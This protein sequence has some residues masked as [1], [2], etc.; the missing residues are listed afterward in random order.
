[1]ALGVLASVPWLISYFFVGV[2]GHDDSH[3]TFYVAREL[4][5]AGDYVNYNRESVEQSSSM[6]FVLILAAL[7]L[8]T[9]LSLPLL[10]W[11][12]SMLG[13]S[14]AVVLTY[15][16]GRHLIEGPEEHKARGALVAAATC[17]TTWCFLYWSTSAMEASV[18]AAVAPWLVI[19]MARYEQQP[20][21]L[22]R[23][24][25]FA[26]AL[27][28]F[29]TL[30]PENVVIALCVAIALAAL[31]L[32]EPQ[33]KWYRSMGWLIAGP[34]ALTAVRLFFFGSALPHPVAA[35]SGGFHWRAGLEY[36]VD[37]MV[38]S[39]AALFIGT[40]LA[41]ASTLVLFARGRLRPALGV[42]SAML[43][44]QLAFVVGSGGDW[45][46]HGRF[47]VPAIPL[48]CVLV[49]RLLTTVPGRSFSWAM[50]IVLLV[51]ML[52]VYRNIDRTHGEMISFRDG[53]RIATHY[54]IL[55]SRFTR[56]ELAC[57]PHLRD[58]PMVVV[59]DQW[60]SKLE[61]RI[62]GPPV[63]S[64]G[65]AGMIPYYASKGRRIRFVDL[66]DVTSGD[67]EKCA[68]GAV[69]RRSK[70]GTQLHLDWVLDGR[71]ETPCGLPRPHVAFGDRLSS[72]TQQ[73]LNRNGYEVVYLQ[74]G[75]PKGK[76]FPRGYQL[77]GYIAVRKDLLT[78]EERQ[79]G[80]VRYTWQESHAR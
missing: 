80:T 46:V 18:A 23:V 53:A 37:S 40:L 26:L 65:Q 57:P 79:A 47:L 22:S 32:R 76:D 25:G 42:A 4:L 71:L 31:S 35:K 16:L 34:A 60:L 36:A 20:R 44:S 10:G 43:F 30:R 67:V 62:E 50:L 68:P 58:A 8:V 77:G 55:D 17:A 12:V 38:A 14:A 64:S 9:G 21:R 63:L 59:L 6:G 29:I 33:E 13:G 69:A 73:T 75:Q 24:A 27:I 28:L 70:I 54:P 56:T 7:R 3:I 5:K 41:L 48:A 1:M 15:I 51:G 72:S 19:A 39:N 11:L 49:A 52:Q 61:R 78:E 74:L 45:M 2:G 66:W